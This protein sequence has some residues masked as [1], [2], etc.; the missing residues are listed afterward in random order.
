M[1]VYII[2]FIITYLIVKFKLK[3]GFGFDVYWFAIKRFFITIFFKSK[4]NYKQYS[5]FIIA[6]I[7]LDWPW[8]YEPQILLS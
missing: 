3:L 4:G 6:S 7:L 8:V 5:S 2:I 1:H